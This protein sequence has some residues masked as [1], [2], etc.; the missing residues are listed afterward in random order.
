MIGY[1]EGSVLHS[2]GNELILKTPSG[3]GYQIYSHLILTAGSPLSLYIAHI[4]K[5]NAEELFGFGSIQEKKL[6]ELLN[7]VR[8]VGPKSSYALLK[9]LPTNTIIE[10]ITS[11]S[12]KTLTCAVGIG[13]KAAAQII[14]DLRKKIQVFRNH[15]PATKTYPTDG[16]ILDE[17]ISACEELGLR[18]EKIFPLAEKI[19][20]ANA[21]ERPEELVRLLLK[22]A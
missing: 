10:A 18:R 21:I 20:Q 22:E 9:S 6:F 15:I 7:T 1:L 8:G 17:A 5:E 13:P 4:K 14:L 16:G 3:I 2:D 19:L 11:N 12:K